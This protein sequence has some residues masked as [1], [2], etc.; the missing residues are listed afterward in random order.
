MLANTVLHTADKVG[1]LSSMDQAENCARAWLPFVVSQC[2]ADVASIVKTTKNARALR[3][4]R[5]VLLLR[6]H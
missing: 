4:A 1:T 6:K 5:S 3:W 2:R